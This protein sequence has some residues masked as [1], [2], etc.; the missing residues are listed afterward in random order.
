MLFDDVARFRELE[1][2][3]EVRSGQMQ[4]EK[5]P[6]R[7]LHLLRRQNAD[8]SKMKEM[9]EESEDVA[10]YVAASDIFLREN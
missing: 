2:R 8:L 7:E 1:R 9:L 5:T 4:E 6:E 10:E 3:I